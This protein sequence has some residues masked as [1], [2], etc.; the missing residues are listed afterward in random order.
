M[1][2]VASGEVTTASRSVNINGVAVA[3]GDIIGLQNG[4][5]VVGGQ[6]V[7]DVVLRLLD[8]MGAGDHELVT[9]YSGAEV[10]PAAAEQLAAAIQAAYPGLGVETHAGGQPYYQYILSVE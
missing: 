5:L 7:P 8:K 3:E 2:T 4:V 10:S 1:S 6:S 9:L